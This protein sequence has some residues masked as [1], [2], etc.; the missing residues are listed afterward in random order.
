[1]V[2]LITRTSYHELKRGEITILKLC[3]QRQQLCVRRQV[4]RKMD[5]R[6]VKPAV[7]AMGVA[8]LEEAPFK[9]KR[10]DGMLSRIADYEETE[11]DN[12]I[13]SADLCFCGSACQILCCV[14]NIQR[15]RVSVPGVK[16]EYAIL[17]AA[18]K[19]FRGPPQTG[20]LHASM[21][22]PVGRF[23]PARLTRAAPGQAVRVPEDCASL[24]AGVAA[25]LRAQV[26]AGLSPLQSAAADQRGRQRAGAPRVN[27]V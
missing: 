5:D 26:R 4:Q 19:I 27:Q 21:A 14:S 18:S 20:L 23:W 9:A 2:F 10:S 17:H 6:I 12:L 8:Y 11:A 15:Y 1:M 7:P 25:A 16:Q 24:P 22:K 13:I 3:V